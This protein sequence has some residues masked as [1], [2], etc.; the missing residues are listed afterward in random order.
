MTVTESE[1]RRRIGAAF[2][3]AMS[4][5]GPAPRRHPA[6]VTADRLVKH[7]EDWYDRLEPRERDDIGN[8][9]QALRE[10]AEGNR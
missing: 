3:E 2:T 5:A 9:V 8:V 7:Y 6:D 1:Y 10:I 4:H